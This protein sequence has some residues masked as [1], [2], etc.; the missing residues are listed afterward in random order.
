MKIVTKSKVAGVWVF[1][2]SVSLC[3]QV[4]VIKKIGGLKGNIR[5]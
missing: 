4:L 1:T 2:A 3:L 5:L